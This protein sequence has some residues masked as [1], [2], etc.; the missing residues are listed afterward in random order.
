MTKRVKW[1]GEWK[2]WC[3]RQWRSLAAPTLW[4]S[5]NHST[6]A[7]TSASHLPF[8][9]SHCMNLSN[10]T[11]SRSPLPPPF[12]FFVFKND[13]NSKKIINLVRQM[14]QVY[15]IAINIQGSV[16]PKKES[17][18]PFHPSLHYYTMGPCIHICNW[19]LGQV[20]NSVAPFYLSL[21]NWA[22]YCVALQH[23]SIH[24][25]ARSILAHNKYEIK[26]CGWMMCI[27]PFM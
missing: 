3:S 21:I 19:S 1:H 18:C 7:A 16:G 26:Q 2:F 15:S 14:K 23:R 4:Q 8:T 12:L 10:V 20:W 13:K 27:Y 17:R 6:F 5:M 22:L 25:S 24:L 11:T 9:I